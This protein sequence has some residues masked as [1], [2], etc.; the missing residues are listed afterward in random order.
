[1]T[2]IDSIA[3]TERLRLRKIRHDDF[4]S[5]MAVYGD[6]SAMRYVGD[7]T[8]IS[9]EDC[10]RWIEITL[11]NYQTRGYGMFAVVLRESSQIVGF[12]GLVHPCKQREPE[13]KYAYLSEFWGMGIATEAGR[14]LLDYGRLEHGLSEIIATVDPSHRVS[15][16][17]LAK[18]GMTFREVRIDEGGTPTS[19]WGKRSPMD[20][21]SSRP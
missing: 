18:C 8:A 4:D 2:R 14:A 13:L 20:P 7:G 10:K 19:V 1:M 15:Q 9:A 12:A 16:N 21:R 11:S 5:M 17:V 6:L 3:E